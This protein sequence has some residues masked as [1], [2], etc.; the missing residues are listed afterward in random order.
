MVAINV[1]TI[2]IYVTIMASIAAFID[3]LKHKRYTKGNLIE[4]R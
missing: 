1:C 3:I 4:M 2:L